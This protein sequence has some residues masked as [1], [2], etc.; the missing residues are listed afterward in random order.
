MEI[1]KQNYL[2]H[3]NKNQ[4]AAVI[5]L[6]GSCL[7]VAGAGSGKTRKVA[8]RVLPARAIATDPEGIERLGPDAGR[9]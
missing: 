3:L 9:V 5:D 2:A 7:I 1:C 4:K 6:D 8:A